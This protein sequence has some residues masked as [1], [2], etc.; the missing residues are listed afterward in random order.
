[1]PWT[2]KTFAARHNKRLDPAKAKKA[3]AIANAVLEKTGDDGKAIRIANA[4]VKRKA[5]PRGKS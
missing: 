1:M 4:A 5:K 2:P 3:A